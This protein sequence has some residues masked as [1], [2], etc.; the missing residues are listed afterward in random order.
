VTER[1]H[2][3]RGENPEEKANRSGKEGE[4]AMWSKRMKWIAVM[5]GSMKWRRGM[6]RD[7]G[8]EE[9]K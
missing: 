4:H 6:K 8:A 7:G 5:T 2:N 9:E 1:R 3:E